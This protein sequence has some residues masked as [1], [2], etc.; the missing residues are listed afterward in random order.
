MVAAAFFYIQSVFFTHW[1]WSPGPQSQETSVPQPGE[2]WRPRGT[3]DRPP[4]LHATANV[5]LRCDVHRDE[6]LRELRQERA[7][8]H[9][10]AVFRQ[11]GGSGRWNS[12]TI[13]ESYIQPA[14]S[15]RSHFSMCSH[16]GGENGF[17]IPQVKACPE[18][19]R[20]L[21]LSEEE[22]SRVDPSSLR[23]AARRLLCDSYMCLYHS[24]ELSLYKWHGHSGHVQTEVDVLSSGSS[25][26][27]AVW[28]KRCTSEYQV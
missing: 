9:R 18:V 19:G 17:N 3:V 22:L 14:R 12:N 8:R 20:Y 10:L 23:E 21:S 28:I 13:T 7:P 27:T 4:A 6:P 26:R 1:L 15:T 24:P 11:H 16:T 5:S 2:D 25:L